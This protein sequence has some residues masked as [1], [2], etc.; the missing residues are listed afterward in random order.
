MRAVGTDLEFTAATAR[1][2]HNSTTNATKEMLTRLHGTRERR[3]TSKKRTRSHQISKNCRMGYS[4]TS[5]IQ[6]YSYKISNY[7]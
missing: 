6:P 2:K 4:S 7:Y 5:A 1:K 3:E